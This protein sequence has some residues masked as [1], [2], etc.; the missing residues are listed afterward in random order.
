MFFCWM[1]GCLDSSCMLVLATIHSS[2]VVLH[3]SYMNTLKINLL[4]QYYIDVYAWQV[5]EEQF[6]EGQIFS[7][8][9]VHYEFGLTDYFNLQS[10][11]CKL[12][13]EDWLIL[14]TV[15]EI[16]IRVIL[17][18]Q[19]GQVSCAPM[20]RLMM[21]TCT[22]VNCMSLRLLSLHFIPCLSCSI[23][24]D[25]I[26]ECSVLCPKHLKNDSVILLHVLW[27]YLSV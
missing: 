5:T 14:T 11:H 8:I 19:I 4:L 10:L 23:H 12:S 20:T 22:F 16:G 26:R 1:M 7:P 13:R 3:K 21:D 18:H 6:I 2:L 27:A 17:V 25:Y 24:V 9:K 15:W